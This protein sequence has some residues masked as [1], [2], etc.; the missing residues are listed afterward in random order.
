MGN[1]CKLKTYHVAETAETDVWRV[2]CG[3]R[4]ESVRARNVILSNHSF[5]EMKEMGICNVMALN[6]QL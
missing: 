6:A 5:K 1:T 4:K 2:Q 3:P